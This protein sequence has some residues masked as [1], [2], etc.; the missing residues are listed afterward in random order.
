MEYQ[1]WPEGDLGE[2]ISKLLE[3]KEGQAA[4][5][6]LNEGSEEGS[7]ELD[8]LEDDL[9]D[10]T[11]NESYEQSESS[12]TLTGERPAECSSFKEQANLRKNLLKSWKDM[13]RS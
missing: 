9:G 13:K 7:F 8:Y 10:I 12:S 6:S 4:N 3:G 2:E 1:K 11:V 5:E